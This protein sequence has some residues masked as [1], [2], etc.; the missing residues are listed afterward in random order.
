MNAAALGLMVAVALQLARAAL[1]D[2]PT[3]LIALASNVVL[4]RFKVNA[5]WLLLA[6]GLIG[7]AL[8]G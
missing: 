8:R 1:T 3:I 7:F 5:T 4:V 2:L 6:G